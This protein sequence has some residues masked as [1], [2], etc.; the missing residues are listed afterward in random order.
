MTLSPPPTAE[1]LA[2]D[3]PGGCVYCGGSGIIED[4]EEDRPCSSCDG[5]GTPVD[6]A[7]KRKWVSEYET[8]EACNYQTHR[9]HFCGADLDHTGWDGKNDHT[10]AFC[11]PD[12]VEHEPGPLCTWPDDP[13]LNEYRQ[14]WCYW[15]HEK[16]QLRE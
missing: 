10:L 8:C 2:I 1:E 11:R 15:D 3:I 4:Y 5:T 9:C 6:R 16:N 12:L 14:P 13:E 7:P